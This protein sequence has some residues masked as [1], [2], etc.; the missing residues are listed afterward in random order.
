LA[1]RSLCEM[2]FR[3]SQTPT[4]AHSPQPTT[5]K[6]P[7]QLAILSAPCCPLGWL[8]RSASRTP[9]H[10]RPTINNQ[11]P[12][13][14]PPQHHQPYNPGPR[15]RSKPATHPA[16][17]V[18]RVNARHINTTVGAKN[19]PQLNPTFAR[20]TVLLRHALLFAGRCCCQLT[21]RLDVSRTQPCPA[22]QS[23]QSQSTAKCLPR[24]GKSVVC[25]C[26][27]VRV[28]RPSRAKRRSRHTYHSGGYWL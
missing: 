15:Q 26:V 1:L 14:R 8:W 5:P 12:T 2:R 22:P 3:S 4:T 16:V 24:G 17:T 28:R 23:A 20:R 7:Q 11:P 9:P 27:S 21:G 18:F 19:K 6:P 13:T 25:V 10:H